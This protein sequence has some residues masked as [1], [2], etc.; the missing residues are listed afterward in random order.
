MSEI[1]HATVSSFNRLTGT[2]WGIPDDL[3]ADVY[4]HRNQLQSDHRFLNRGDRI[5]YQDGEYNGR[6]CAVKIKFIGATTT[7]QV[8][9]DQSSAEGAASATPQTRTES[10]RS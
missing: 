5:E 9:A 2:G 4:L 1:K 6:P 10:S 8:S 7:K 3:T